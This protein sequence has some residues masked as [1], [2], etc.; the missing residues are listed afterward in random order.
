VKNI[1]QVGISEA[2]APHKKRHIYIVCFQKLHK[3]YK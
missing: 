3:V 2:K 1:F